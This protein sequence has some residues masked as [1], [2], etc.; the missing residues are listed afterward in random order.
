M[1]RI[2]SVCGMVCML[3]S[4][5]AMAQAQTDCPGGVLQNVTVDAIDFDGIDC[6]ITGVYVLGQIEIINGATVS[7]EDSIVGGRLRIRDVTDMVEASRNR[8]TKGNMIVNDNEEVIVLDNEVHRGDLRVRNNASAAV[9]ANVAAKD[10]RCGTGNTT[11]DA[12]L[13]SQGI[14]FANTCD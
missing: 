8:V 1:K 9:F 6:S 5:Q 3:G 7:I 14:G 12:A 11:L 4:T 13:N 2:L 10:I